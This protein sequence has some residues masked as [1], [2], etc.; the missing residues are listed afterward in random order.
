MQIVSEPLSGFLKYDTQRDFAMKHH[1]PPE[2]HTKPVYI[3]L[4]GA[5]ATGSLILAGLVRLHLA[6]LELGHPHGLRVRCWDPDTISHANIGRQLFVESEIGRNKA[7]TLITRYNYHF[8]L[9]WAA[10]PERFSPD[11][12]CSSGNLIVISAVDSR[13]SRAEISA[14]NREYPKVYWIDCGCGLDYGQ[15][16]CGNGSPEL[17]YP[18]VKHPELIDTSQDKPGRSSCSMADSLE[19]HGLFINQFIATGVLEFVWQ[20]FRNGGLEYSELYFN[21]KTGR[22]MPVMIDVPEKQEIKCNAA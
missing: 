13:K 7:V 4:A 9:D 11:Q 19:H 16:F 17:P 2:F 8:G 6:M 18:W 3:E 22:M 1:T 20:L 5:G 12:Y 10:K 14:A 15:V 21:I